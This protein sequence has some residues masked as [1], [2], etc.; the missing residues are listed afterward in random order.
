ML[1]SE[2]KND[3][4][5]IERISKNNKGLDMNYGKYNKIGL[6]QFNR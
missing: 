5:N 6:I 4:V 1:R 2:I 3:L